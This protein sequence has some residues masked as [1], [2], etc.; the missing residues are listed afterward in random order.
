MSIRH[1]SSA[2]G[3]FFEYRIVFSEPTE[4]EKAG[5]R[6]F[7]DMVLIEVSDE[8]GALKY[9]PYAGE[10]ADNAI[11]QAMLVPWNELL[12]R[13]SHSLFKYERRHEAPRNR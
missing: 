2:D 5:G 10:G 7:F 13:D 1:F 9:F 4:Y 3:R 8:S 6:R 12:S 11:K